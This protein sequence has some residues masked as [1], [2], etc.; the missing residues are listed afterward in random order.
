MP[1]AIL[2][3]DKPG[4]DKLRA[5]KRDE[6][7]RYLVSHQDKMLAGGA[8]LEDAGRAFGG[9]IIFDTEDRAEAERFASGDPFARAGLF[10][11]VTITRWRKAFLNR[12][13][14]LK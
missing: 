5:E 7:I 1:F 11:S 10:E 4:H 2:T 9:I 8:M 3:R 14:Y 12:E 13:N 6:H